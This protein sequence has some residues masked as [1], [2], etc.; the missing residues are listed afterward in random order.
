M[1]TGVYVGI[2]NYLEFEEPKMLNTDSNYMRGTTVSMAANR[3]SYSFDFRGPSYIC[4]SACSS[5]IY[6]LTQAFN[7]LR[8]GVVDYALVGGTHFCTSAFD[9][10]EFQR[11]NVI[12]TEGVSKTFSADRNGYVRSEGVVS[13]FIQKAK[14]CRRA[15]ATVIGTGTNCDGYKKEGISF[16][17]YEVHVDLLKNVYNDFNISPNDV[18]YFEAHGTGEQIFS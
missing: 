7:D 14:D 9:T 3:I 15:Y 12:S 11:L 18:T 16:P 4:N 2:N 13:L 1:L 6:A 8:H 17:S 5:S 10:S